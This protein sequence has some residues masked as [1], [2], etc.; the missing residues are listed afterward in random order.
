MQKNLEML[1]VEL[2]FASR[3]YASPRAPFQSFGMVCYWV[4]STQP[5]PQQATQGAASTGLGVSGRSSATTP[6]TREASDSVIGASDSGE[7][8]VT[9]CGGTRE[10]EGSKKDLQ[11]PDATGLP[12]RTAAPESDPPWHHHPWQSGLA[13]R[14]SVW[15]T[16]TYR[17]R[18]MD[19][20]A[21]EK[22]EE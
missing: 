22:P 8:V 12:V 10:V 18:G 20:A 17:Q 6:V 11:N 13:V 7:P 15:E 19:E 9:R 2:T 16:D 1:R 21:V 5:V 4:V 3:R 14:W